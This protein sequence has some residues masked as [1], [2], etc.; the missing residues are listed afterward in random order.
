MGIDS[1]MLAPG[2][3]GTSMIGESSI[4]AAAR[5]AHARKQQEAEKEKSFKAEGGED[6]E[7]EK[8]STGATG[9]TKDAEIETGAGDNTGVSRQHES[10]I[11]KTWE[12]VRGKLG[13]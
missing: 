13:R 12:R 1:T 6:A 4:D 7:P 3:A 5:R 8:T 10:G 9:G 2:P 11:R